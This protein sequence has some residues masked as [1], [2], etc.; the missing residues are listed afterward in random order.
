MSAFNR[1]LTLGVRVLS[2]AVLLIWLAACGGGSGDGDSKA[3]QQQGALLPP[4]G[5]SAHPV[6][7]S[8][9]DLEWTDNSVLESGF[10]IERS[11][12][13][14]AFAKVGAAG[15]NATAFSDTGLL[16]D[17]IYHYRVRAVNTSGNSGYS[18]VDAARTLLVPWAR[19][20]GGSSHD[21]A[22]SISA[23]SDGGYL[24]TGTSESFGGGMGF[25]DIWVVKID[26]EGAVVWQR[27]YYGTAD[28]RGLSSVQTGDGGYMVAG[29]TKSFG[30]GAEDILLMKLDPLGNIEWQMAYGGADS[31]VPS[32]VIEAS[33]GGFAV[34][35]R[36]ASFSSSDDCWVLKVDQTGA[37]EWQFAYGR[38][39][40]DAAA[41]IIQTD[42]SGFVV[43]GESDSFGASVDCWIFKI[44]RDGEFEWQLS[45]GGAESDRARSI[46]RTGNNGLIVTGT[47]GSFFP[48]GFWTLKLRSDGAI[49]WQKSYGDGSGGIPPAS[50]ASHSVV[51]T[52]EGGYLGAG[53]VT[54]GHGRRDFHVIKVDVS[55]VIEWQ[56]IYDCVSYDRALCAA[57]AGDGG[58]IVAGTR[59]H[60][61]VDDDFW[62]VKTNNDG[63][64]DFNA[65]SGASSWNTS[66][67][68]ADTAAS[69]QVTGG[70]KTQTVVTP[71]VAN[72]SVA[73][74]QCT[75]EQQ[76]P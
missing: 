34:A 23:T 37:I 70:V 19:S 21:I 31:D 63:T 61:G 59:T 35:G 62:I 27:V 10:E 39:G 48:K 47:S 3:G 20:Y 17:R 49:Q 66:V 74:T 24:L 38:D 25:K 64:I 68:T 9:I 5:L 1:P 50:S 40:T 36:S 16:A 71:T 67:T 54:H 56:K 55:G 69:P 4:S 75:V 8:R 22:N 57:G 29:S 44:D 12:D 53:E 32:G 58:F 28:G 13:G 76:A 15:P 2:S 33:D 42:D 52:D 7:H 65:G 18:N 43:A 14:V 73:P 30:A 41:S 60:Q 72:L 26:R 11:L 6:A 45:Y 46:A 51:S